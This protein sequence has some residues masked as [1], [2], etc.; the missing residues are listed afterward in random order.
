MALNTIGFWGTLLK[1]NRMIKIYFYA[2]LL[3]LTVL[4]V[5]GTYCLIERGEI[6]DY[7]DEHFQKM[8][9]H[10]PDDVCDCG[11]SCSTTS[12]ISSCKSSIDDKLKDTLMGLGLMSIISAVFV[13]IGMLSSVRLLRWSRLSAPVLEGGATAVVLHAV[14]LLVLGLY[15]PSGGGWA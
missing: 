4:L 6:K 13:G 11:R 15:A 1:K 5:Y 7:I 14:I 3:L 12:E 10:M 2:S 9:S 8:L